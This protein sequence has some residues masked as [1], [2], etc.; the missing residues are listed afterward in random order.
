[1]E[2]TPLLAAARQSSPKATPCPHNDT[3]HLHVQLSFRGEAIA[4]VQFALPII[5]TLVLEMLPGAFTIALVGHIDSPLR[6]DF[7]AASTLSTMFFNITGLSIGFGLTT[8]MDTLCS[9]TV[10]AGKLNNLGLYFQTGVLVLGGMFIPSV[11]LNYHA[12][13]FLLLLRQDPT[14]AALAGTFSRVSV[15]CLP[16]LFLYELVQ[17]VLQ[18]QNIVAPMAYIAV[19][20]NAMYGG[21]GYYL[22]YHTELGFLGAAYA[23]TITNSL[24]P[25]L[26]MVYLWWNPVYKDWWPQDHCHSK[27]WMAA[28]GHVP[29][30]LTLGV[31]GMLMMLM[32]WWAFEVCAVM[33]GWMAS[34]VLSITVQSIL[35]SLATQAYSL[36]LGLGI[37]TTVR[38]GNALGANEPNR[39]KMISSVALAVTGATCICV[40]IAFMLTH[41][42]LPMLFISDTASIAALQHALAWFCVFELIDGMNCSAQ[43]LLKGMGKQSIGAWVNAAAYYLLGIPLGALLAFYVGMDIEGLWIGLAS[44]LFFGF[45]VYIYFICH[46]DWQE[47]AADAITRTST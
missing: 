32:E 40:S 43:S 41:A 37:A 16:G 17:K 13:Y 20:S 2:E 12:E 47:V 29:E 26:A 30:F 10:G 36:F 24:L 34:P 27:Q 15:W 39:A 8:A 31:P 21:I 5:A 25:L 14:V 6:Q 11:V 18:A 46:V 4:L 23:R 1:M 33:A 3:L 22:C 35:V 44:G 28:L 9:Q 7:V 42:Y 19:V 38:L 45:S